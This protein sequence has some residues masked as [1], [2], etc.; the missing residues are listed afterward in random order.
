MTIPAG[1]ATVTVTGTLGAGGVAAGPGSVEFAPSVP[2][3]YVG[4]SWVNSLAPFSATITSGGVFSIELPANDDTAGNPTSWTYMVTERFGGAR[5]HFN[6]AILAADGPT[7]DYSAL[8]PVSASSGVSTTPGPTGATGLTGSTGAT[9]PAGTPGAGGVPPWAAATVYTLGKQVASPGN[10]VV[11]ANTAHTS[12]AA[13]ATDVAKWVLSS[14]Y[15]PGSVV[16][17][18]DAGGKNAIIA[19]TA[20]D[21]IA[22]DV[23]RGIILSGGTTGYNNVIGGDGSATVGTTT[24]NT[25]SAGTVANVSLVGGY[26]NVAGALSSKIISDHSYVGIDATTGHNAIY[27]GSNNI[28]DGTATGHAGIFSGYQCHVSANYA[29]AEGYLN[30]VSAVGGVAMGASHTVSGT[31]AVA[32][33]GTNTASGAYS[34]AHGQ[35]CTAAGA[36]SSADGRYAWA[37]RYGQSAHASNQVNTLGDVQT[38]FHTVSGV[39]TGATPQTLG[40]DGGTTYN[41]NHQMIQ[42]STVMVTATVVG[43]TASGTVHAGFVIKVLAHQE[44]AGNGL[45]IG[46]PSVEDFNPSSG[47]SATLM[48]ALSVGQL[49]IQVTGIAATTIQWSAKIDLVEVVLP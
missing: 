3:A 48:S 16:P 19:S 5:T 33:G 29:F 2:V 49:A 32:S 46:V 45:L 30:T 27:G 34:R 44:T 42:G 22:S 1:V 39:T 17:S 12:S 43:R 31:Y 26:D 7:Q 15:V 4:P 9:G 10:D 20:T 28:I 37:R 14:T 40:V 36:Y 21:A 11:T 8:V 6:I 25:T 38:S 47:T 13:Y 18:A 41:S 35:L 24:P 23:S